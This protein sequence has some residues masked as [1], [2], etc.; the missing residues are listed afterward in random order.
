MRTGG[1]LL[2]ISFIALAM[3]PAG[4]Q[5]GET[6]VYKYDAL[7]RLVKTTS[8]GTANDGVETDIG[9]DP[10]GNRTDYDVSNSSGTANPDDTGA[11]SGGIAGGGGNIP[12]VAVDDL[13]VIAR[14]ATSHTGLTGND[15]DADGNVPLSI[16][17]GSLSGPS[18]VTPSATHPNSHV[19]I[20]APN[21]TATTL[22]TATYTVQDTLGATDT[23]TLTIDVRAFGATC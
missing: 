11:T 14:C 15:T 16:V 3:A 8:T 22:F 21:V 9:Y 5:A 7:G 4:L 6:V 10:A 19:S 20:V 18:W 23:G 12:P 2:A 1:F 17:S 13:K